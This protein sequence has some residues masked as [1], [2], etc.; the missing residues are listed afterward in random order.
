MDD[1][2]DDMKAVIEL[3]V[4]HDVSDPVEMCLRLRWTDERLYSA[5]RRVFDQI[6]PPRV[7]EFCKKH[8]G[9]PSNSEIARGLDWPEERVDA[10]VKE[11][12]RVVHRERQ[13][14]KRSRDDCVIV[15]DFVKS[16]AN[17][18]GIGTIARALGWPKK[19]VRAAFAAMEERIEAEYAK[20]PEGMQ[21]VLDAMAKG[22]V[23][24]DWG[25][26]VLRATKAKPPKR[27]YLNSR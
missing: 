7:I 6:D 14:V 11:I 21:I 16:Q 15:A 25:V 20:N 13:S 19:R 12:E 18:P 24:V 1:W 9:D 26:Q 22:P 2:D 3:A 27:A 10:A 17:E 8:G 4:V 5:Q 23:D